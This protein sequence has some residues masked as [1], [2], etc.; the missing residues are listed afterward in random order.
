L[1]RRQAVHDVLLSQSHDQLA[2]PVQQAL[3]AFQMFLLQA[4]EVPQIAAAKALAAL[5]QLLSRYVRMAA[6]ADCFLLLS[7]V[8]IAALVP[9]Y[10]VR[11]RQQRPA[12]SPALPP[13]AQSETVASRGGT[14]PS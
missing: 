13:S 5:G 8:F 12:P 14:V 7:L 10:I 11:T 6:Y 9:A 2:L 1:E 3:A 4:G